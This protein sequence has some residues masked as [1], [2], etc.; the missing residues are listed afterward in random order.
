MAAVAL[1]ARAHGAPQELPCLRGDEGALGA[2]GRAWTRQNAFVSF[3]AC[4]A[5][6]HSATFNLDLLNGWSAFGFDAQCG[7]ATTYL[8][9]TS[10]GASSNTAHA[11]TISLHDGCRCVQLRPMPGNGSLTLLRV[12]WLALQAAE[13][14]ECTHRMQEGWQGRLVEIGEGQASDPLCRR[15]QLIPPSW[16]RQQREPHRQ[17]CICT[18][19]P[20]GLPDWR[21]VA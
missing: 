21:W 11:G 14:R 3:I 19:Q 20:V 16:R 13:A 18:A 17:L 1:A 9:R 5:T 7:N 6:L 2:G 4:T 10:A 15:H 8:A 12:E